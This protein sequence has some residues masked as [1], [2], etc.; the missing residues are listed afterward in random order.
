MP[1]TEYKEFIDNFKPKPAGD[2]ISEITL[3]DKTHYV[4]QKG[5]YAVLT[6]EDGG[7]KD[8]IRKVIG[9]TTGVAAAVKGVESW[10]A[11]NDVAGVLTPSGLKLIIGKAREGLDQIK[12]ITANLPPELQS[13]TNIVE[14]VDTFL[15]SAETEVT[16]IV[17]GARIDKAVNIELE[18]RVVFAK[19]G[20]FAQAGAKVMPLKGGPLSGLPGG[21]F[22]VAGG[23]TFPEETVAGLARF[24]LDMLKVVAKDL[25]E[26]QFKKLDQAYMQT[27]K[28]LRGMAMELRVGK[29]GQPVLHNIVSAISV[30]DAPAYIAGAEKAA[31]A[32]NDLFK[33]ANIP[34]YKPSE[35]RRVRVGEMHALETITDLTDN[36]G[37]ALIPQPL[38]EAIFGKEAKIT[39]SMTAAGKELV[40]S[41]YSPASGLKK[42]LDGAA[43]GLAQDSGVAKTAALLPK[44]HQWAL[45]VSPKGVV[46]TIKMVK[47][48]LEEK[49]DLP[50][51]PDTPPVGIGIKISAA[52]VDARYVVPAQVLEGVGTLVPHIMKKLMSPPA[53]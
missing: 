14:G 48:A 29:K 49:S 12:N 35:F 17:A 34:F 37:M 4:G 13:V 23:G 6:D 44:G 51:F 53:Q 19:D 24:S 39:A 7:G 20:K 33:D 5:G 27:L 52:G 43:P 1:G 21:P 22:V 50:A 38:L 31:R 9:S 16:H 25:G 30:A 3:M 42:L 8:A 2:K 46:E 28:G 40:L 11:K 26:D 18:A 47:A 15:K 41:R 45:Y 32:I 36:P 10:L